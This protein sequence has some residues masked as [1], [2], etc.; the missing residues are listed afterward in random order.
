[1]KAKPIPSQEALSAMLSYDERTGKLYWKQRTSLPAGN[2]NQWNSR[3]AGKEA[4][5][6]TD[7]NGYKR[8]RIYGIAFQAHRVIWKLVHGADPDVIDHINREPSD[9]RLTNLRSGTMADNSRNYHKNQG[10]S[11]FRG[12]CWVKRDKAWAA[13][14]SNGSRKVSLGNYKDEVEAAKAYDAAARRFHGNFA[15]L[16][17]PDSLPTS[18]KQGGDA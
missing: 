7:S 13:R 14:I 5:T 4:F 11:R 16:N 8:G 15:F 6:H 18:P 1:M 2:V 17:F 9:N 12:V 10:A 3:N